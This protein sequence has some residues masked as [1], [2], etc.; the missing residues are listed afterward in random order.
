MSDQLVEAATLE[1][2]TALSLAAENGHAY[3][4]DALARAHANV[5]QLS[6]TTPD[7][8]E[9]FTRFPVLSWAARQGHSEVVLS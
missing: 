9:G 2:C 1:G 8:L 3:V 4:I 5:D 6:G 7:A